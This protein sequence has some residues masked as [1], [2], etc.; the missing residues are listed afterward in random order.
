MAEKVGGLWIK[1]YELTRSWGIEPASASGVG[2]L[3]A[4]ESAAGIA[5][6]EFLA[7]SFGAIVFY[8]IVSAAQDL[9]I[10]PSRSPFSARYHAESL[11]NWT[12]SRAF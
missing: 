6:G 5:V 2:V 3:G 10:A 8:G 12:T 11:S 7:F 1:S 9:S 4:G